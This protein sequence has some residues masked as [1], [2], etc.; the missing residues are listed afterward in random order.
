MNKTLLKPQVLIALLA[1]GTMVFHSCKDKNE[2]IQDDPGATPAESVKTSFAFNLPQVGKTG[3]RMSADATQNNNNFLGMYNLKLIPLTAEGTDATT[4]TSI[5]TSA[6]GL[7]DI[8]TDE[9]NNN[10]KIYS[11]VSIPVGTTY[12][13]FYG[14]GGEVDPV[15]PTPGTPNNNDKFARGVLKTSLDETPAPTSTTGITFALEKVTTGTAADDAT[16]NGQEALLNVLNAVAGA[17]GWKEYANNES[18]LPDE[19]KSVLTRLYENFTSLKAGSAEM[20]RLTLQDL[21]NAVYGFSVGSNTDD[22]DIADAIIKAIGTN[23]IFTAKVNNGTWTLETTNTYPENCNLPQGA[24]QL[25]FNNPTHPNEFSYI[26]NAD[27]NSTVIATGNICFPASLYYFTNTT[28]YATDAVSP[29]WPNSTA[30]WARPASWPAPNWYGDVREST[31]AI[32]LANNIQYSVAS[33]KTTVQCDDVTT[34]PDAVEPDPNQIPIPT[35]GFPVT[36]ILIAGQPNSVNWAFN[37]TE[38]VATK[39]TQI[40]YDNALTGM[41]AKQNAAEGTNYTLLLANKIGNDDTTPQAS[42]S[43]VIELENTSGVSF[44]G[45]DGVVPAGA[46]FYLV[47]TLNPT[48]LTPGNGNDTGLTNPAVFMQDYVTTAKLTISSLKN[49]SV[50]IPDLRNTEM[51]LGISVDLDWQAGLEFDVTID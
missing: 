41:K 51:S 24:A 47:A 3:T 11:D 29:A 10:Q 7:G 27:I 4:F 1:A 37:S 39:H 30:D 45:K 26:D 33:L 44:Q 40:I 38:T 13:L 28:L 18:T 15:D 9:L 5:I 36:G 8:D 23:N 19:Q 43:M 42:V 12:F 31:H 50:T 32:A 14:I 17:V 48:I 25:E 16:T 6:N 22:K 20:I 35:E 21:Y 34:L 2:V 49:A 46:K